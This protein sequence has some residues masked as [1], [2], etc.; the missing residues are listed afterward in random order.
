VFSLS[1]AELAPA[2]A[3]GETKEEARANAELIAKTV[4]FHDELVEAL[5][6]RLSSTI[7]HDPDDSPSAELFLAITEADKQA[8]NVLGRLMKA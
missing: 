4:N 3:Y 8:M 2:N 5:T 1:N 6:R 7:S